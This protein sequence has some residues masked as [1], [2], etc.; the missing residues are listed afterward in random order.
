MTTV[1]KFGGASIKDADAIRRLMPLIEAHQE[2]PLVVVISAM[3]KTTNALEALLADARD[4]SRS[5]S[6]RG[7]LDELKAGHEA[8]A[9]ACWVT[10]P[11]NSRS[12][13]GSWSR[14]W[15]SST[16]AIARAPIRCTT[17]RPSATVSCSPPR[18][19]RHG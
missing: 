10:R 14:R 11:G 7:R 12:A 6:Y 4:D 16:G 5:D 9:E 18:S 1:F 19:S 8:V 17:T 2:R 13:S 3:G 15:M